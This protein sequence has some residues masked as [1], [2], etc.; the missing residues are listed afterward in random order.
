MEPCGTTQGS[1]SGSDCRSGHLGCVRQ[2]ALAGFT[3]ASRQIASKLAPTPFG[4][5]QNQ[6]AALHSALRPFGQ[7]QKQF[8]ALHSALG[9]FGQ[10]QDRGMA[11]DSARRAWEPGLPAICRALAVEADASA[12]SGTPR[13]E[14]SLPLRARS[15]ASLL[16]RPSG[17]I[18][19]SSPHSI[20]LLRPSG[21]IKSRR[22]PHSASTPFGQK[23]A[24]G[25]AGVTYRPST[26]AYPHAY[27]KIKSRIVYRHPRG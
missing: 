14:G 8:A 16:L 19:S 1:A 17:R 25:V 21:R 5:N 20:L 23:Q 4:Q 3:A 24:C 26:D 6:F 12:V 27:P 13:C 15:R 18:K 2:T 7:N 22:R 10:N 11:F 9:P